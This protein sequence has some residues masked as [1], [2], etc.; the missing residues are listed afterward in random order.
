M[1]PKL[2]ALFDLVRPLVYIGWGVAIV[3]FALD[4]FA[5][6]YAWYFGVYWI[7]PV[8][9]IVFGVRKHF[10]GVR[11]WRFVRAMILVGFCVWALPNSF[12]Y[13]VAQFQGWTHGRFD[14]RVIGEDADGNEI[15]V[16]QGKAMPIAKTPLGK[17]GSGVGLAS[18][19]GLAGSFWMLVWGIPIAW[20][21]VRKRKI[22]VEP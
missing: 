10:A 1:L 18:L 13:P 15:V 21:P 9:V 6:D 2:R 3:R 22:E 16:H 19:T 4:V 11:F 8:V 12:S 5:R 20:L 7:M 17:L 14:P